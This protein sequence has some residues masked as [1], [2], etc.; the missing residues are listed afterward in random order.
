MLATA[1][2]RS[3]L[4]LSICITTLNR[5][6]FI[7]ATLDSI[8]GQITSDCEVVILDGASTDNTEQ[9]VAEYARRFDCVRY[10]RQERNNGFDRDVDRAV[11][12]ASGEYCWLMSDD[13]LLK[14]GAIAAVLKA[15]QQDWNL[16]IVNVESRDFEMSRVVQPRWLG[17]KSDRVYGPED[18]D[19][20]FLE[21]GEVWRYFGNVVIKRAIWLARDRQRYY[22]SWF[23]YLGVIFQER[24][25]GEALVIAEPFISYRMSN[26]HAF[27]PR[28]LEILWHRWPALVR[29][30]DLS[31]SA[32]SK[33][34]ATP[35][36][37][38]LE[39]LL[40]RALGYYSLTE[41]RR[42]ISP[43]SVSLRDTLMPTLVAV[44]PRVLVK[45]LL[46]LYYST[47]RRSDE[48]TWWQSTIFLHR[49]G[50]SNLQFRNR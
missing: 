25:R 28:T 14:P 16:V 4:K 42:L 7:G 26:T 15:L 2:G 21:V 41:Y 46:V 38:V 24:L 47:G 18:T 20:L 50:L 13:D 8:L 32:K 1:S 10:I 33:V 31:E 37:R 23:I 3:A 27:S 9:V 34:S 30:L 12:L 5:A 19:R 39:L 48:G 49:V 35:W 22:G 43:R 6:T 11:E 29:S 17:F 45:T 36:R 44:L 40:W